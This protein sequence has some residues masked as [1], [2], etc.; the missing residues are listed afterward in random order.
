MLWS[1][2]SDE[3]PEEMRQAQAMLRRAMIVIA[4]AVPLITALVAW[5][6]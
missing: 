4:V 5:R 3:P 1:D 2:P 6:G